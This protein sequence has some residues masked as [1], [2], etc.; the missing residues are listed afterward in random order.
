M[1][2]LGL[3]VLRCCAVLL[4]LG[5][6]INAQSVTGA[7]W[8][9]DGSLQ[10]W[11]QGGGLGV[12]LFF[13][14]SGFLIS[15]LLFEEFHRTG[16]VDVRRFLIR[17]GF[18]LYPPLWA[19]IVF[20]VLL[21]VARR[22]E[23]WSAFLPKVTAEMCFV[24]NYFPG[25]HGHT[26]TLAVEEHFYIACAVLV[27]WLGLRK[28]RDPFR[29]LPLACALV[30]VACVLARM[31]SA[32]GGVDREWSDFR[33]TH[34]CVDAMS[35]G[36]FLSYLCRFQRLD[37]SVR[38]IPAFALLAA[39]C[40][41]VSLGSTAVPASM[42]AAGF[43]PVPNYVGSGL[44]VLAARRLQ[45]TS[46]R[47]LG[48]IGILG[49]TSYSTYLWHGWVNMIAARGFSKAFGFSNVWAYLFVYVAGSFAVG[50]AMHR[51]I[52]QR[53][54]AL[55]N[56][57]YPSPATRIA[58]SGRSEPRAGSQ[59]SALTRDLGSVTCAEAIEPPCG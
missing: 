29:G 22:T 15:G 51:L 48:F 52:E 56:H 7:P 57:L 53:A 49:A 12:T 40:L 25:M 3:D 27:A 58:D 13:V 44:I 47:M 10:L 42:T 35:F 43:A 46:S 36:V 4:V 20:G 5:Q 34:L 31:R 59:S 24:Q 17:R 8:W 11:R 32:A 9:A 18:K 6:H 2:N 55:R 38:S 39:G 26:W 14:L 16:T 21:N 45:T 19:L 28:A 30:A 37:D 50:M 54:M 23:E 41:V 33:G 1:R